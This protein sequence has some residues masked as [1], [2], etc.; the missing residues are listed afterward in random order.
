MAIKRKKRPRDPIQLAKLIGDIATGQTEDIAENGKDSA[1]SELGRSGGLKG[2]LARAK[3]L[4]SEQRAEIARIAAAARWKK[5][6]R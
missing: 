1:A 2:G 6:K 3:K 4:T 5:S